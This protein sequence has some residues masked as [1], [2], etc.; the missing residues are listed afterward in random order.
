MTKMIAADIGLGEPE[1][2][3]PVAVH[4]EGWHN[5]V[6]RYYDSNT[7]SFYDWNP[8]RPEQWVHDTNH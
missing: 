3:W 4:P 1:T 2:V 6:V 7:N 8:Y 5:N